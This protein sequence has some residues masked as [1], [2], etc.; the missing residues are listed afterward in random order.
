[1][2][3]VLNKGDYVL[4]NFQASVSLEVTVTLGLVLST[5]LVSCAG[6]LNTSPIRPRVLQQIAIC[7][8]PQPVPGKLSFAG[9]AYGPSHTG[10][11]P[12]RGAFP[13]SEEIEADM[14]TL[15]SLTRYIRIYS[16][17][18]SADTIIR[19]AKAAHICVALGIG[20]GHNPIENAREMTAGER[21]TSN[22][23]V[24]AIIV[25]NED[26]SAETCQRNNYAPTLSKFVPKL[27]VLSQSR[28]RI[29][30]PSGY[31]IVIWRMM[32]ISLPF[33]SILSGRGYPLICHTIPR[34]SVYTSQTDFS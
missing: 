17:T 31:N 5:L 27:A 23:A 25:G 28:W 3:D 14:P 22:S 29:H 1:M 16:S 33:T 7:T 18:G 26:D 24:H 32:S 10:Q 11:D 12:T 13:S 9:L 2:F 30:M 4:F 34:S 20:L 21:L 6:T 19:V 15:A 8:Q